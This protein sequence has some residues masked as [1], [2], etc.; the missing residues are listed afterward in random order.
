M[1]WTKHFVSRLLKFN[2]IKFMP[3]GEKPID[4]LTGRKKVE[5]K[6]GEKNAEQVRNLRV[7]R[8]LLAGGLDVTG[9]GLDVDPEKLPDE[10][11]G[12]AAARWEAVRMRDGA[13]QSITIKVD[14]VERE[15]RPG[16]EMVGL[17]EGGKEVEGCVVFNIFPD[18]GI[19]YAKLDDS[20]KIVFQSYL[21][22]NKLVKIQK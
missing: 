3:E 15:L 14:G 9:Y 12:G 11:V 20:G 1:A 19:S 21:S 7:L 22:F 4:F 13:L 16:D 10:V 5:A 6:R 8:I 18:K 2:D 17:D